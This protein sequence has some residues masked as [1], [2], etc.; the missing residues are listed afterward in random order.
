MSIRVL[1]AEDHP[2]VRSGIR[3]LLESEEDIQVQG[4]ASNGK[5][6]IELV[7]QQLPDLVMMDISMPELGGLEATK[8]LRQAHPTLPILVLT[9]HEDK[10]YFFELLNAGA[11]GYVVKGAALGDLVSAV[12]AVSSG[13]VYLY[14]SLARCLVDE[15]RGENPPD[16]EI[17]CPLSKREREV[18]QLTAQGL[19][20]R[21][22]GK[23]LGISANTVERHRANIMNK[24]DLSN[25]AQLVRYAVER[26]LVL[27]G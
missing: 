10:R 20:A 21:E 24:L 15:Y 7:D 13:G 14:P 26:N 5:E 4:E 19:T 9:M 1:I 12:R 23:E 22:V 3:L 2:I 11:N 27:P 16:A 18:L 17:D 6:V 8:I 25:R